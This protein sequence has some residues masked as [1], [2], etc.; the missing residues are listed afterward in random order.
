MT[1]KFQ[2]NQKVYDCRYG[3]GIVTYIDN[4]SNYPVRVDFE[5]HLSPYDFYTDDG[6]LHHKDTFPIL[7]IIENPAKL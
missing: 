3:W 5:G 2:V 6:K 1:Q 4:E 7:S